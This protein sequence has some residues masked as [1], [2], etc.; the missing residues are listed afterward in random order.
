MLAY[1]FLRQDSGII[2]RR[3]AE[4]ISIGQLR[5]QLVK[6]NNSLIDEV[7]GFKDDFNSWNDET[8]Q[9]WE[10][11]QKKMADDFNEYMDGCKKE[12][13]DLKETYEEKLRLEGPAEYW[14][15]TAK[16]FNRQGSAALIAL[17]SFLLLGV[18]FLA[19]FYNNWLVGDE[20]PVQLNSLQGI[21]IFGTLL[22]VYA[23]LIRTWS[24]L[25]FSAFHLMRDAE[26]K[27]QLTY[28]YLS[29]INEKKIDET[30]RDIVLQALFSRSET[31]LLTGDS[32]PTMPSLVEMS[33]PNKVQQGK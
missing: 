26:E 29:L 24:R 5:N 18:V 2:K 13:M 30:S 32:G 1:E 17:I 22:A 19:L 11:Q 14:R 27:E 33:N 21:V 12:I 8:R 15:K 16:K 4:K 23:F 20:T 9:D 3:K 10:A 28:L 25:T 31:G 7:E 6:T